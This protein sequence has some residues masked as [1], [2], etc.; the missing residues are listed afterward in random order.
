MLSTA[1]YFLQVVFCSAVMMGYYW[2]VLRDKKFHQY[3]RFYLMSVL[4]MSWIIPLIKIQWTKPVTTDAQVINFLSI[5]ADNNAEIDANLAKTSYQFTWEGFAVAAYF[6][7]AA[8]MLGLLVVGLVRLYVLLKKH[9]CKNVG[10]VY[11]ILTQVKGTPFSFFRYIFWHE[12]ID[13][14]S[15]AGQKMLE[16]ELTH[17]QQKHSIDKV[18]IQVVLVAGWFN[19][20]FW[21]LKK[22]MEMIHEFIADNKSVQNGDSASLAQLLLTAA[23]PQQQFLL[24]TPFFFSP[25]K[26]RLAMITNNKNPRFSY[27]RRLVILPLLAIVVVLVAFRS[28]AVDPA[29][30]LSVGS[31]METIADKIKGNQANPT[32]QLSRTFNLNKTYTVV[33]DAGHGGK[34]RGAMSADSKLTEAEI[35]LMLAKA[36]KDANTNPNVKIILTRESDITNTVQEKADFANAKKADLFIS[37]HCNEAASIQH[38]NGKKD[39]NPAKGMEIYIANKEKA[40]NYNANAIFANELANSVKNLNTFLGIKSRIAGIW[41]LQA[42]KCPSVII[43]AG[44]M[45]NQE[46]MKLMLDASYQKKFAAGLLEGVQSYLSSTEQNTYKTQLDTVIIKAKDTSKNDTVVIVSDSIVFRETGKNPLIILDGKVQVNAEINKINPNSI[47]RMEVLKNESATKLYGDAGRNGVIMITSKVA[48]K[49]ATVKI[50]EPFSSPIPTNAVYYVDGV[51]VDS[52]EMHKIEPS[53][54]ASINVWKGEKAMNKF[55]VEDGIGVIEIITKKNTEFKSVPNLRIFKVQTTNVPISVFGNIKG[56]STVF[57]G[58]LGKSSASTEGITDLIV[59]NDK[60]V[61]PDELNSKYKCSDFITGGAIDPKIINGKTRKG[62]LFLSTSSV[63]LKDMQAMI[64]KVLADNS[65]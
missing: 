6:L 32:L 16:H 33:I 37:L 21:L 38:E 24:T 14:R 44:F 61:S 54:I 2:L 46:D 23:Y 59:V 51:K 31:L 15:D 40:V 13:L 53:K 60:L 9:S 65:K 3:N 27:L 49:A 8:I 30:S 56:N 57:F 48:S 11:L 26:R 52:T 58:D 4:M 17:V 36:V 29:K 7:I 63:N 39:A 55:G 5:V 12:A 50:V 10:D 62:V 34:D 45:T 43:E 18:L 64:E 19:P 25:I 47:E 42:V 35:T 1:Y 28:K 20:F 41:V 22:E